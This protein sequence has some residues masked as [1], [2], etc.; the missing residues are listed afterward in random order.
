M[1]GS[2]EIECRRDDDIVDKIEYNCSKKK[3]IR[4]LEEN[5]SSISQFWMKKSREKNVEIR[6]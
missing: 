4:V 3:K 6:K 5:S 2:G 1:V